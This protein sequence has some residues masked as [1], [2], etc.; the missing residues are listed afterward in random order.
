M[1]TTENR[2]VGPPGFAAG[3]EVSAWTW[4]GAKKGTA[5]VEPTRI[6]AYWARV[7]EARTSVAE[8]G[9]KNRPRAA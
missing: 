6:P 3:F 7:K 1:P 2:T 5:I 8:P 4:L 9:S